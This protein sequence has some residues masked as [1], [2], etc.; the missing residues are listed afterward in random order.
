ME[1]ALTFSPRMILVYWKHL[2]RLPAPAPVIG[3]V[4]AWLPASRQLCRSWSSL[5]H[6]S[7]TSFEILQWHCLM[8]AIC[9][10]PP[11]S[12]DPGSS[13]AVAFSSTWR[14]SCEVV[15][16]RWLALQDLCQEHCRLTSAWPP[17]ETA[18]KSGVMFL[19]FC[20]FNTSPI[21]CIHEEGI[22]VVA[23]PYRKT[24]F[25]ASRLFDPCLT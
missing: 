21:C 17:S 16:G 19:F 23:V 6:V 20:R 12:A 25:L 14:Y 15:L 22:Q 18:D 11:F 9:L 3:C 8:L 7:L 24:C 10:Y 2:L 4:P 13:D 5:S 1:T